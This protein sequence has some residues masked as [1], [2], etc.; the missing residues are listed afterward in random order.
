MIEDALHLNFSAEGSNAEPYLGEGWHHAEVGHRWTDG[1]TSVLR[2]PPFKPQ[3]WFALTIQCWPFN[4]PGV[5]QTATLVLNGTQIANYRPPHLPPVAIAVPG[6]LVRA[7]G[8]N[9]LVLHHPNAAS[10]ALTQEG[11]GDTR[12]LALALQALSFEPLDELPP[13]APHLLPEVAPPEDPAEAQAVVEMFQ[14]LGQNCGFGGTQRFY[15]AEPYGLLRFASI[16]P[17]QLVRGLRTRF[18]GVGDVSRLHFHIAEDTGELKGRHSVYGL[19]YHT[20]KKPDEIDVAAFAQT[21]S[22]RLAYLARLFFEQLEND[23]KIF[24]R[25]KSFETPGEALALHRLLRAYHPRARLLILDRPPSHAP[26]RAGRVIE[27]RPGLYRG[28][29]LTT[30]DPVDGPRPPPEE[31]LRLC[32]TV[33]AY[34]RGRL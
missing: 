10:P 1:L 31:W 3:P 30:S 34:E 25:V 27:L 17:D 15:K 19:D 22:R 23:E 12:L 24:L 14:S 33:V 18:E 16:H 26:E 2:L 29:F 4:P 6:E 21:E 13:V 9:Q 8:E 28:Y 32:A 11:N 7:D 5:E 20:F